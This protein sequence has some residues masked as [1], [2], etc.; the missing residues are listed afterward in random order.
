MLCIEMSTLLEAV[1]CSLMST[2]E[3]IKIAAL[4]NGNNIP[5]E[6]HTEYL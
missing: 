2:N 4:I 6:I 1:E 5:A 3:Y